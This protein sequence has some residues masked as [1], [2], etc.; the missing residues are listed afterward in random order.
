M[1][2]PFLVK[3]IPN[4]WVS[5]LIADLTFLNTYVKLATKGISP[6]KYL[7]KHVSR[8]VLDLPYKLYAR[9][10]LDYGDVMYHDQRSDL[11]NL[12]EQVQYKAA[13]IVLGCS[14]GTSCEKWYEELGS[15]AL[16]ERWH[17]RLTMFYKI[18]NGLTPY[19]FDH[20]PKQTTPNVSMHRNITRPPFS[21][22][23]RYDNS[24]FPF[25][26]NSW[27]TRQF[28]QIYLP[29]LREFKTRLKLIRPEGNFYTIRENFGIKLLTKGSLSLI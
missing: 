19:L 18:I 16:S 14:Q 23:Q 8:K 28:H 20:I 1:G 25:C 5:I 11:M 21:R 29:S 9:P 24:F 12:I 22:K 6:L 4:T 2:Y 27:N 3:K 26:I 10:H 7:S 13:L 15:E 17:R